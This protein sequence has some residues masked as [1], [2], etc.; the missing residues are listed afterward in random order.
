MALWPMA[1]IGGLS[2]L[3]G[4]DSAGDAADEQ[5]AASD[6]AAAEARRQYDITRQDTAPY[7]NIGTQ[8]LNTIGGIYGY[9]ATSDPVGQATLQNSLIQSGS[10]GYGGTPLN[11]SDW[12]AIDR[13][14]GQIR[15]AANFSDI[16]WG[17][18]G[19]QQFSPEAAQF[20]SQNWG[21]IRRAG[22][23][24]DINWNAGIVGTPGYQQQQITGSPANS[25]VGRPTAN[26]G[27]DNNPL[28]SGSS[29]V[30]A[31]AA[32]APG[33]PA[34]APDYSAFYKSPDYEFVRN[35]GIRDIGNSFA[36]RGGSMSG[37]ALKA[38]TEFSSGLASGNFYNYLNQQNNLAGL[39]QTA[40]NTSAN[41][42]VNYAGMTGNALQNAGA[43]RAS[44]VLG[45]G[46]ALA[47]GIVGGYE[48]FLYR[49]PSRVSNPN[50]DLLYQLTG[51]R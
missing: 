33:A 51:Q 19:G 2:S 50:A 15:P 11:Q 34:S 36:A 14:W 37:N 45:Q 48:N 38:L 20:L 35:E 6:A 21:N 28:F 22:N 29:T 9:D 47:N 49:R 25:T 24:G 17:A 1:L 41:A 44:G 5:S 10:G 32:A 40:V 3:L 16:N 12:Q 8:A 27:W 30:G 4:Y 42:G 43:A 46:A 13:V 18:H 7:R 23:F 31:P 39:G 26:G